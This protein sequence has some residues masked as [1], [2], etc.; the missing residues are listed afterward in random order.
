M[1]SLSVFLIVMT[2]SMGAILGIFDA[3]RK[4]ESLKEVMDNLN[5]ALDSMSR[6]IRFGE[7][8]HCGEDVDVTGPQNCPGGD[9]FISFLSSDGLQIS[10]KLESG[11]IKKTTNGANENPTF[12]EVTAPEMLIE[13]LDF[14]VIGT[15]VV[16]SNTL[17]PK[18]HIKLT[19][20]AGSKAKT[21][22]T[23][24]IQTLVSQRLLDI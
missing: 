17:Q 11:A 4:S 19:G 6:E 16:P 2:I 14:Y 13:S 20:R 24:T 21:Q 7:N 15:G 5:F 18:V 23:F 10:Y 1:T 22:S 3:N 9:S 8:Y 12:V